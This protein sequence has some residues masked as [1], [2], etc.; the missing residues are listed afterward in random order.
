[1]RIHLSEPGY[2]ADIASYLNEAG[3]VVR[4]LHDSL[5]EVQLPHALNS[6]DARMELEIYVTAWLIGRDGI[7]AQLVP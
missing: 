5:I 3:C 1:M 6:E 7:S 4:R 2:L